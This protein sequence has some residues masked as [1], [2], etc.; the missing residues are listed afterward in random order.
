MK[1]EIEMLRDRIST[2]V[3]ELDPDVVDGRDAVAAT[4][5][6]AQVERL[7]G[8]AKTLMARRVRE[9]GTW[10][11]TGDRS[12]EAWLARISGT[13][14][15][16]AIATAETLSRL[17]ELPATEA[18]LRDGRLSRVQANEVSGAATAD[19][20]A[21]ADL[22][23][24]AQ[25]GTVKALK[26]RANQVKAAARDD[27]LDRYRRIKAERHV[28]TWEDHEGSHLHLQSTADDVAVVMTAI[29]AYERPIFE[30]ARQAGE[31][32]SAGAYRADALVAMARAATGTT[33]VKVTMPRAELRIRVDFAALERGHTT[34]GEVCEI[35][36]LGPIPVEV[37]R[38]MAPDSIIDLIVT[39]GTDVRS[40]V[41]LGRTIPRAM[42]VA[43][44]ER[45]PNC[46][47]WDCDIAS[48]LE[49]DHVED[50]SIVH[51]T[52][53]ENLVHWCPYHHDLK[54]YDKWRPV[55][56]E[57]GQWDLVPPDERG[58]P[59]DDAF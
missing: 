23:H 45:S 43:L 41:S 35:P 12:F 3:R 28:R 33:D 15:G 8:A 18:A 9:T 30:A 51:E 32:E 11:R 59:N 6:F 46:A 5:V 13:T 55:P 16:E 40:I 56:R 58:P 47:K 39:K 25:N 7:G 42:K 54:T 21:E 14:E 52:R 22:L 50:Y 57:D 26:A 29:A 17:E 19:P 36:G 2:V 37:A 10:A 27:E 4:E 49:A 20:D 1:S 24:T 34:A 31:R 38:K 48:H 53:F 44:E